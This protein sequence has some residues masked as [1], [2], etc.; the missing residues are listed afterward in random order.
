[1]QLFYL[2]KAMLLKARII[3]LDEAT[4]REVS[5]SDFFSYMLRGIV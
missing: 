5:F 4:S 1:M 3:L 2:A